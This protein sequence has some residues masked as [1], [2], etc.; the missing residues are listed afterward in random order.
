M[1]D[2]P[3]E[4]NKMEQPGESQRSSTSSSHSTLTPPT[5]RRG[6]GTAKPKAQVEDGSSGD[7]SGEDEQGMCGWVGTFAVMICFIF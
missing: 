7:S 1:L 3:E 6:N 2:A 4:E 5:H